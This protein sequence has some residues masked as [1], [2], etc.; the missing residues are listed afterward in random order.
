MADTWTQ[1]MAQAADAA[2]VALAGTPQVADMWYG[3]LANE[4][5]LRVVARALTKEDLAAKLATNPQALLLDPMITQGPND[6]VALL[7][8]V[9]VPLVYVVF[10]AQVPDE[11]FQAVQSAFA[12]RENIRFYRDTVNLVELVRTILAD[13]EALQAAAGNGNGWGVPAGAGTGGRQVVP[14]RLVGV[15]SLIGGAGKT[16]IASNLAF[17]AAR[18]GIPTLLV[19]L[20]AP[21]DLPLILG[22]KP[23]PNITTWRANPAQEGLKASI[24]KRDTVDVLAGFPDLLTSAQALGTPSDAPNSLR[25]LADQAIRLG[26]AAIIFDL[27]PSIQA[28]SALAALNMLVLVGRPSVEGVMRTVEGYR[29]VVER[30]AMEN[31]L[32]P[33]TV[34]IVVNRA[35]GRLDPQQWQNLANRYL[36]QN[37]QQAQFPPVTAVIPDHI[38]VG[39]AQDRADWPYLVSEPLR[40]GIETLA[41]DI[42]GMLTAAPAVPAPAGGKRVRIRLPL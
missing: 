42:F 25:A 37:N 34:R 9:R 5:R 36:T 19:G 17:A 2:T 3:V 6:L 8:T 35:G 21:D 11:D 32:H 31:L 40:N 30:M 16:T 1:N 38:A 26:Y 7:N 39:Q 13:V 15:W 23:T 10:P 24:Q 27:P 33:S 22:L 14:V 12:G 20:G 29:T 28:A 18:R 41:A 4:P